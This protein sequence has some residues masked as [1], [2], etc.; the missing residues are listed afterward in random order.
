M[1]QA[2]KNGVSHRGAALKMLRTF[3]EE[4][5]EAALGAE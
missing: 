5:G 1:D 2:T 3:L 4:R